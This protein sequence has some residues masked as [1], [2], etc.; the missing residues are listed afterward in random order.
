MAIRNVMEMIVRDVL[1]NN[2]Q[3]LKLTC[4]CDRCLNDIMAH[5]LNHLP[6]RYIVNSDHQPY[7]RVMHEADRDGA[8][9]I[10]RVVTQAAIVV[11]A[12]PRCQEHKVLR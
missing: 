7:V 9:N 10:L 3:E 12:N 4:S 2:K 6:P 1:L 5:A 8:I 11:S